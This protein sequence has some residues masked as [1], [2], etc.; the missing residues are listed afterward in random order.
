M[1]DV[2]AYATELPRAYVAIVGGRTKLRVRR[3]V[4]VAFSKDES[5]MGFG[6]PKEERADLVA[7]DPDKFS[8]P[9][10]SDM[11][12]NWVHVR[13]AAIDHDEMRELVLD[14]WGMCVPKSVFRA[15]LA[16]RGIA[17]TDPD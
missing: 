7:S 5:V 12:Y 9:R 4:F 8:M 17:L 16:R 15:E 13:L 2:L 3:I 1:D 11:R 6:F 14:A 10:Q